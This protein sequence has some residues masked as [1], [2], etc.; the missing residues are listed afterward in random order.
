MSATKDRLFQIAAIL[1]P[2][3][4]DRED[5]GTRSIL[6]VPPET[7]LARDDREA[8]LV[9]ARKIPA[10]QTKNLDRIEIAVAPF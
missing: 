9:A 4:K 7:I 1:H 6:L 10:D 8:Q 5:N 3:D 2:T